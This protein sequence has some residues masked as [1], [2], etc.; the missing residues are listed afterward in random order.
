[1]ANSRYLAVIALYNKIRSF[2]LVKAS[3]MDDKGKVVREKSAYAGNIFE[4]E[5]LK[6]LPLAEINER[7]KNR[8]G[9]A[10][11]NYNIEPGT[12]V[13]FEIVF[14]NLPDNLSEFTVGAVSS[15][16]GGTEPTDQS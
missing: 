9:L 2:I 11:N 15:S 7:M 16:P 1:L 4:E 14:E 10:K 13:D 12:S 5:E 8:P 6:K 3:I